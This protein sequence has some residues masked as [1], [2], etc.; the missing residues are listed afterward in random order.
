M[1]LIILDAAPV[2][3][4]SQSPSRPGSAQKLRPQREVEAE[5]AEPQAKPSQRSTI[6]EGPSTSHLRTLVQNGH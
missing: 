3:F 4:P 1:I 2:G 5:V 6:P